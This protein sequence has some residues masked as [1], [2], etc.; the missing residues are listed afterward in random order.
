MEWRWRTLPFVILLLSTAT[1]LADEEY[2]RLLQSFEEAQQKWAAQTRDLKKGRTRPPDPARAFI[3]RFRD[4]AKQHAGKP[5]ALPALAWLI[6]AARADAPNKEPEPVATWAVEALRRDHAASPALGEIMPDLRNAV[7]SVNREHLVPFY[8]LVLKKNPDREVKAAA[9]FNLAYTLWMGGPGAPTGGN[10]RAA[11][12]QR[13][14]DLFRTV[15]KDY[16]ESELA[17]EAK[18]FLK[19]LEQLEIGLRAPEVAGTDA[20]GRSVRLSQFKGRVVVL[21]FWGYW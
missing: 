15:T 4:Y 16:P 1:L 12:K 7:D 5:E 17:E 11:D 14:R 8:E 13:A 2:D 10:Q 9:M 6:D 21:L 18:D 3:P 19:Q 20:N